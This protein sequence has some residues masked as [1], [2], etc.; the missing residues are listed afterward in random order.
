M[1]RLRAGVFAGAFDVNLVFAASSCCFRRSL[2]KASALRG[3]TES[4]HSDLLRSTTP[5]RL[6][7]QAEAAH[8]VGASNKP[9]P[10]G[11]DV[12]AKVVIYDAFVEGK[13]EAPKHLAR[14]VH[15]LHFEPMYEEFRPRTVWSLSNAFTSAFEELDPI[16]QFKTTAKLGE[17][18]EARFS[19]GFSAKH[20]GTG[21]AVA[22][23]ALSFVWHQQRR[24]RC[25]PPI[26]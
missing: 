23:L 26:H 16:L 7:R 8:S 13:L 5:G 14:T 25:F 4:E 22:P 9:A 18:L 15:N 11:T 17:F 6:S 20:G 10:L 24:G 21:R 1:Y 2:Q 19:Q 3:C 12:T